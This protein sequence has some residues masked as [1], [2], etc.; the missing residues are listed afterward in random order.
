MMIKKQEKI[1]ICAGAVVL[2]ILFVGGYYYSYSK[3]LEKITKPVIVSED[4]FNIENKEE[5]SLL[6]IVK[7]EKIDNI[8]GLNEMIGLIND[9]Q[10]IVQIGPTRKEIEAKYKEDKNNGRF[11]ETKFQREIHGKLYK[12]DLTSLEKD[13]FTVEGKSLNTYDSQLRISPNGSKLFYS[14]IKHV[15][16]GQAYEY[17]TTASYIYDIKNNTNSK[18]PSN[19]SYFIDWSRNGKYMIDVG[20]ETDDSIK[21]NIL[22]YDAEKNNIKN[23]SIIK[24]KEDKM[25]LPKS[26]PRIYSKDGS[27]VYFTG[28]QVDRSYFDLCK[29]MDM[30]WQRFRENHVK[31]KNN[32]SKNP[33]K[34]GF[35][36]IQNKFQDKYKSGIYKEGIYRLNTETKE[37]QPIMI[38]PPPDASKETGEYRF[39]CFDFDVIGEEEKIVFEGNING[40]YGLFIYDIGEKKFNKVAES[41]GDPSVPFYISPDENKIVYKVFDGKGNKGHWTIYAANIKEDRLENKIL[42]CKDIGYYG[43]MKSNVL[44]S[45]NSKKL[46]IHEDKSFDLDTRVISEKGILHVIYFK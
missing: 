40:E 35:E 12:I 11:E 22:L 16:N 6:Q 28:I 10:V 20:A 9:N 44:W 33:F 21:Y 8:A 36:N 30:L 1:L 45:S 26:R 19:D 23:V 7:R 41:S 18:T 29:Q 46:I 24:D 5:D 4:M 31:K 42:L 27:D 43:G 15:L 13:L 2:L 32:Q 14:F 3:S 25:I 34:E 38:I 37:I 39:S 17:Q